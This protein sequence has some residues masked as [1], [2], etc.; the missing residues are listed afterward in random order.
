MADS[1]CVVDT[2]ETLALLRYMLDHNRHHGEELETLAN[3]LR[4]CGKGEAA[5][6]V[7]EAVAIFE[8]GNSKLEAA[9]AQIAPKEA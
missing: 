4:A 5:A 8:S 9:V 6:L 1:N 2:E 7:A 3:Q